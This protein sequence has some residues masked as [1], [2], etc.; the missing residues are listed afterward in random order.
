MAEESLQE[1]TEKATPRKRKRAREEGRVA[2]SVEVP[3]VFVLLAGV[4]VLLLIGNIYRSQL[5][6]LMHQSFTIR[7]IPRFDVQ[8]CIGL[9]QEVVIRYLR[10][11]LPFMATIVVTAFALELYQVGLHVSLKPLQPKL[12]RFNIVQG[13]RRLVSLKS[14]VDLIKAVLKLLIIG[15][16]AFVV[17]REESERFPLL[18]RLDIPLILIFILKA[19]FKIF[20]VVLLIMLVIAA[21]DFAFQKWQFEKQLKMTKQEVK[22]EQK[23]TEGDPQVRSRIRSIQYQVARRRMM[24]QVPQ[25]DVVVTNPTHLALAIRYDPGVMA[26]PEVVAKGAGLVAERIKEVAS[27]NG[28]PVVEN[29]KLAQN[30]YRLVKIGEPIP[31]QL[32]QA[33]AEVLAYVYKLKGKTI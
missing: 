1:K 22:E 25:A 4:V 31:V 15:S 8:Y 11:V 6:Q 13:L 20:I 10:L 19:A 17:I 18:Y 26:A 29:K 33:V 30:L 24:Q 32:Y 27:I 2:K 7:S 23:Q 28:I 5:T 9:L 16:V 14:F 3:S 12:D 21:L